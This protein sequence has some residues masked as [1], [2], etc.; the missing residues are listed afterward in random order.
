MPDETLTVRELARLVR[1]MR[2]EQRTYF[3]SRDRASLERSKA[4]EG[5]VDDAVRQVLEQRSLFDDLS[6]RL[7]GDLAVPPKQSATEDE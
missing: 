7:A 5:R 3:R 4:L 1:E 6:T 2:S